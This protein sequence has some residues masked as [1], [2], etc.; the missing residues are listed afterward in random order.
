MRPGRM[1]ALVIALCAIALTAAACGGSGPV[2]ESITPS[3][4]EPGTKVTIAG[5]GF[6][7]QQGDGTV[8][9]G[10]VT[11]D[12]AYW[13][14]ASIDCTVPKGLDD[15]DYK[16][17]VAASGGTSDGI[18][19]TVGS[20]SQPS[21][22]PTA[23]PS[24]TET[25]SPSPTPTVSPTSAQTQQEAIAAYCTAHGIPNADYGMV[26]ASQDDPGWELYAAEKDDENQILLHNVDGSWTVVAQSNDRL[27]AQKSGAPADLT[28]MP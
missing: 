27:D 28:F 12:V 24:P 15:G 2:V 13:S 9:F 5:E 14:D 1:V 22:S 19:F 16:V 18:D 26:A 17:S 3:S 21:P 6:G 8:G 23:S 25:P 10:T 11:A 20:A 7:A 4:G